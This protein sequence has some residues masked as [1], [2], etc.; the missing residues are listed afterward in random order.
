[1]KTAGKSK[2]SLQPTGCREIENIL[3]TAGFILF[4]K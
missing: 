3:K 2:K 1:M 4:L